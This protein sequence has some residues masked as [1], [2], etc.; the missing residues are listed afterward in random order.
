[1]SKYDAAMQAFQ[2]SMAVANAL[3]DAALQAH[4]SKG[5]GFVAH[6]RADF[7][8]ALEHY[9]AALNYYQTSGDILN[10]L[11]SSNLCSYIILALGRFDEA[12]ASFEAV[13]ALALEH[14]ALN[15]RVGIQFG[16]GDTAYFQADYARAKDHYQTSFELAVATQTEIGICTTSKRLAD[17]AVKEGNYHHAQTLLQQSYH[18]A[19]NTGT[20]RSVFFSLGGFVHLWCASEYYE[21]ALEL[22][23]Y[24]HE[25]PS[26]KRNTLNEARDFVS[27]LEDILGKDHVAPVLTACNQD[28]LLHYLEHTFPKLQTLIDK[29]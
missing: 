29:D 7:H 11:M 20:L 4:A 22:V 23:A 19:Q 26:P 6:A 17:I 12:R 18:H 27:M 5:L 16:L 25:H 2:Q 28:E 13:D 15:S 1:M 14:N 24:L 10:A 8:D 3:D 9:Q 21:Q